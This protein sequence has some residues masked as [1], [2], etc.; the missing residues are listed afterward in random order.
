MK[1]V[2]FLP[3]L[4]VVSLFAVGTAQ[5]EMYKW[6]DQSGKIHYTQTP[7]PADAKGKD[8]EGDI[9]LAT[10]NAK[11]APQSAPVGQPKAEEKPKTDAEAAK[12][13]E[14]EHRSYC[15]QQRDAIKKLETNSLVKL[16]D[17]KGERFLTADERKQ[18]AEEM[19]K[20]L[21]LM[22]SPAMFSH[23]S[24]AASTAKPAE[25][26]KTVAPT[27][28]KEDRVDNAEANKK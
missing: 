28:A 24:N 25:P 22:C 12:R 20:N 14:Q 9:K 17:E 10:G 23:P 16:K 4:L 26:A 18:K 27:P 15:D 8:I 6:T 1:K 13:S 7:P 3:A 19:N 11:P 21:E 2:I 5:A